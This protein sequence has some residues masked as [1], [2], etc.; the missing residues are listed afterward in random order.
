MYL[1]ARCQ[2]TKPGQL[3]A[4]L[5]HRSEVSCFAVRRKGLSAGRRAG[6]NSSSAAGKGTQGRRMRL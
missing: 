6:Q 3:D 4:S 2:A 5:T 1:N